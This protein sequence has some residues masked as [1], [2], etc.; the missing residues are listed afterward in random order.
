MDSQSTN[1]LSYLSLFIRILKNENSAS[2]ELNEE[3]SSDIVDDLSAL[4]SE[5]A[6]F[7][8][9]DEME[10]NYTR[11]LIDSL[12]ILETGV[13]A[14]VPL[15]RESLGPAYGDAKEAFLASDC[16]VVIIAAD[17]SKVSVP[18]TRFEPRY[19][20][21]ILRDATPGLATIISAKRREVG[22]RVDLLERI[23]KEIKKAG[24]LAKQMERAVP[25]KEA[26]GDL[27]QNSITGE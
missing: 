4:Q 26:E 12:K 19:V 6:Q 21:A 25:Q 7:S 18:L 3:S 14:V 9:L 17:D 23:L 2:D 11:K 10:Q 15:Q 22:S 16:V 13:D 20:L 8:E 24:N 1:L 5:F 27:V